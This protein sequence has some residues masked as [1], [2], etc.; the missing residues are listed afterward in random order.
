M[1]R[2]ARPNEL[3]LAL[4]QVVGYAATSARALLDETPAYGP[5]R[6]LESARRILDA[7]LGTGARSAGIADLKARVDATVAAFGEGEDAFAA[8]LDALVVEVVRLQ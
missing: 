4:L 1:K 8:Q 6:L 2:T 5:L 3:E 7:L